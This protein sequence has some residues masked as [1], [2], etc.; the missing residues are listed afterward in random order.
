MKFNEILI[1]FIEKGSRRVFT[2]NQRKKSGFDSRFIIQIIKKEIN[3]RST[4]SSEKTPQQWKYDIG[5]EQY[6]KGNKALEYKGKQKKNKNKN[7]KKKKV[8]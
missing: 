7:N 8:N 5:E 1:V 3:I 2:V 4:L 6:K